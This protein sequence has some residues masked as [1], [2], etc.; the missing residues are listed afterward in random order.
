MATLAGRQINRSLKEVD[1]S[2]EISIDAGSGRQSPKEDGISMGHFIPG[3]WTSVLIAVILHEAAH[4]V[5]AFLLDVKV[6]RVGLNW[7]GPYI[8]REP[9]TRLENTFISL[10]GPLFNLF[11]CVLAYHS[12]STFAFVNG[13]LGIFNLLPFIPS[14]DGQRVYRLWSHPQRAP[15]ANA[16]NA[17]KEV[18][19]TKGAAHK[20]AAKSG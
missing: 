12:A 13:F 17:F 3:Y 19:E 6:E 20:L 18:P 4:L 5:T 9:G 10:T 8:V 16:S 15:H 1:G 14:S 7:R 2:R 11:L